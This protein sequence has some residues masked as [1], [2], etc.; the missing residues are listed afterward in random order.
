MGA[1]VKQEIW[2][3]AVIENLRRES[4]FLNEIQSYDNL[5]DKYDTIHL[6]Q[7]GVSPAVLIDNTS[8]PINTVAY[9]DT[10]IPIKLKKYETENTAISDDILHAA[11]Y[12][13]ISTE[14]QN[15]SSAL[16]EKILDHSAYCLAPYQDGVGTPVLLAS[17]TSDPNYNG[18][19]IMGF[20]DLLRAEAILA[21]Y[22]IPRKNRV[23]L[24]HD[25]HLAQL[26]NE[27]RVL[28]NQLIGSNPNGPF[29]LMS[30]KCYIYGGT[31]RYKPTN[32][33]LAFGA[34]PGGTDRIA[35]QIFFAPR[36][37]R[38]TGS[39][40]MYF[41]DASVNAKYRESTI[42]FRQRH[43]CLPKVL[44]GNVMSIIDG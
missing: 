23:L 17:G 36:A 20:A 2:Q 38:A 26:M 27:D 40:K 15:H 33:K 21:E 19:K 28:M 13:V 39:T 34:L 43:I 24:L 30:F 4:G 41:E 35:S 32:T 44:E 12:D 9:N 8:Y 11:G 18:Y 16:A 10:D 22:K 29:N 14:T 37:F 25:K 3:A 42:G 1:T 6:S 31:A 7:V 5:V